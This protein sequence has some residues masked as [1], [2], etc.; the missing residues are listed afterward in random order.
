MTNF[1]SE[2]TI[3]AGIFDV[4]DSRGWIFGGIA[5]EGGVYLSEDADN[6][7]RSVFVDAVL[8]RISELQSPPH[9]GVRL[10][11][12]CDNHKRQV[13]PAPTAANCVICEAQ[14][15]DKRKRADDEG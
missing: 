10:E 13:L 11:N 1:A 8:K 5:R 3:R 6:E 7:Q 2:T 4:I 14:W 12:L 9:D 15:K